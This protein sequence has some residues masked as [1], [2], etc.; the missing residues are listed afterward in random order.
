MLNNHRE[1]LYIPKSGFATKSAC[2]TRAIG[3]GVVGGTP[4]LADNEGQS[5]KGAFWSPAL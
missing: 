3:Q 4:S 1:E 5:P 2:V